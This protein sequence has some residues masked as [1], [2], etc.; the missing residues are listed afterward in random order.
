VPE[1]RFGV[2]AAQPCKTAAFPAL[3]LKL[4]IDHRSAVPEVET[5]QSI[6]LGAQV[7]IDA[8]KRAHNDTEAERLGELFG[9]RAA[10]GRSMQSLLWTQTSLVVPSFE[11]RTEAALLL[12]CTPGVQV[13]AAKYVQ[14]LDAGEVPL[15]IY[16]SGSVFYST[17]DAPLRVAPLPRSAE[18]HFALP[19]AVYTAAMDHHYPNATLVTLDRDVWR[20]L[21]RHRRRAGHGSLEKTILTLLPEEAP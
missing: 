8:R 6:L 12:P 4:S 18:A 1:F 7:R 17:D 16:L 20:R 5:I 2:T 3:E 13:S 19:L 9:P 10:W 21:E 15:S 14:A 11:A